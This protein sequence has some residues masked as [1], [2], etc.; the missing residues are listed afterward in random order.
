MRKLVSFSAAFYFTDL[1]CYTTPRYNASINVTKIVWP[2][3]TVAVL[4]AAGLT[5]A[6]Y[7]T[8]RKRQKKKLSIGIFQNV[9]I[10]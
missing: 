5:A 3:V 4:L 8:Y 6:A 9:L 2:F 7:L 1:P 10:T